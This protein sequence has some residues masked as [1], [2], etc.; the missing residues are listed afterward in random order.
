MKWFFHPATFFK[1]VAMGIAEVIP[2]IS[3]GTIAFITGIYTKLLDNIYAVL[4]LFMRGLPNRRALQT[5]DWA[6]LGTLLAGMIVGIGFGIS[7]VLHLLERYPPVVWAFFF[8]LIL[9]SAV[10]IA[11]HT[12]VHKPKYL[13]P[14]LLAAVVAWI[15]TQST[16][17]PLKPHP[18]Y[19]FASGAL[20]VMALVLPGISG[21]YILL[22]LG[23]YFFI[24]EDTLKGLLV[25][26]SA[27]KLFHLSVFGAGAVVGLA[28]IVRLLHHF[29]HRYKKTVMALLTG[30]VLGSLGKI[31]PWKNPVQWLDTTSGKIVQGIPPSGADFKI[32]FSQNVL[33]SQYYDT[34]YLGL[35]LWSFLL[36]LAVVY[37]L[38]RNAP[39]AQDHP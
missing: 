32:I 39:P 17:L 5:I 34:P 35:S 36:G 6:F 29:I 38:F 8:G 26:P 33:P 2:G 37:L 1:G 16:A 10:L 9:G 23:M 20:A 25:E 11:R 15:I 13:L 28:T 31:W 21:S 12:E 22:L 7:A 24:I 18:L 4:T 27:Q 3:G 30:F 14:L 19:I